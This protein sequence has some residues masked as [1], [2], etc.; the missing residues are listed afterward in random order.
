MVGF[1]I[2]NLETSAVQAIDVIDQRSIKIIRA[3]TV[4]QNLNPVGVM[5][6]V[7]VAFFIENQAVLHSGAAAIFDIN[8]Q[9]FADVFRLLK[10][11]PHVVCSALSDAHDCLR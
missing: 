10:H 4:D 11:F 9:H 1:G 3:E 2:G 6:E 5:D 7:V 8:A